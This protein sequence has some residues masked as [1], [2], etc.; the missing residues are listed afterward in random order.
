MSATRDILNSP[1]SLSNINPIIFRG[2]NHIACIRCKNQKTKCSGVKPTCD[3]CKLTGNECV[4]P[5]KDRKIIILESQLNSLQARIRQLEDHISGIHPDSESSYQ[6]ASNQAFLPLQFHTNNE[7]LDNVINVSFGDSEHPGRN[8]PSAAVSDAI[9]YYVSDLY[10]ADTDHCIVSLPVKEY[11]KVLVDLCLDHFHYSQYLFEEMDFVADFNKVYETGLCHSPQM[12]SQILVTLALGEQILY[13]NKS[14]Q[15]SLDALN[16]KLSSKRNF[17]NKT[18][19]FKYFLSAVKLFPTNVEKP[20]LATIQTALLIGY[21]NQSL[22]R[23]TTSYMWFGLATRWALSLNLH[24]KDPNLAGPELARRKRVWWTV[25]TL[26]SFATSRIRLP[27]SVKYNETQIDLISDQDCRD[28]PGG[29]ILAFQVSLLKFT[30]RILH[31]VYNMAPRSLY[32]EEKTRIGDN[33]AANTIQMVKILEDNFNSNLQ[34]EFKQLFEEINT[35]KLCTFHRSLIHVYLKSNQYL[36]TTCRPLALAVFKKFIPLDPQIAQILKKCIAAATDSI[37]MLY[38][39]KTVGLL[40]TFDYWQTH[41]LF[42]SLLILLITSSIEDTRDS[43]RIGVDL[44]KFMALAGNH[45]SK[46]SLNKLIQLVKIFNDL[47]FN[48]DLDLSLPELNRVVLSDIVGLDEQSVDIHLI[49]LNSNLTDQNTESQIEQTN[50]QLQQQQKQLLQQTEQQLP[51]MFAGPDDQMVN[52][53]VS[54]EELNGLNLNFFDSL[55]NNMQGWSYIPETDP[56]PAPAPPPPPAIR[57]DPSRE[58]TLPTPL[59]S[60]PTQTR[61][62]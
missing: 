59:F 23:I 8:V 3:N 37:K 25:F 38:H 44:L 54:A 29:R 51:L 34:P 30:D 11:A 33:L 57:P 6:Q 40:V 50:F 61:A 12:L 22:N 39:V 19:G 14:H 13:S 62:S 35:N 2:R 42:N 16:A 21:Y 41:F 15:M 24:L 60:P 49:N 18:P 17:V 9:N 36:I 28:W 47:G 31:S 10:F 48:L 55:L 1:D 7:R 45:V 20:T 27:Q 5:F 58:T 4:Y 43:L 56:A 53:A 52:R 26:D 32:T 46:D